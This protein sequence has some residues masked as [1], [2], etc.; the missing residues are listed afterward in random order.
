MLDLSRILSKGIPFLRTDFYII[1][2]RI[3]FGELTFFPAS[4]MSKFE[5]EKWD[6][7]FGNYINLN[8]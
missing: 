2:D 3:Y 5:P 4:G 1:N 7:V 6:E 8:L